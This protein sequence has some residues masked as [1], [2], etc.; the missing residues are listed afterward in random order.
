MQPKYII[1]GLFE[2]TKISRHVLARNLID[3]LDEFGLR[4]KNIAY[5]KD[6][7][8]NM[9]AMTFVLKYVVNCETLGLQESFND[10]CFG[11]VYS[12]AYQ[13]ATIDEKVYRSLRYLSR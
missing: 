9:N 7:G 6:G 13:Y 5:V 1:V 8:Y 2:A 4:K 11:H 3:L 10:T 12:K